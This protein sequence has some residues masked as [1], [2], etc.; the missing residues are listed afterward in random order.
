MSP[1]LEL[2]RFYHFFQLDNL[3]LSYS[4]IKRA[5]HFTMTRRLL[6]LSIWVVFKAH[7]LLL[8][9]HCVIF[10]SS[11]SMLCSTLLV[12]SLFKNSFSG[13]ILKIM[14]QKLAYL[15]TI[16]ILTLRIGSVRIPNLF[17]C[18]WLC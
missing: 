9:W 12:H 14:G 4:N 7:L 2:V 13:Y 17:Q 1:L 16:T 8:D 5:V 15:N 3:T 18:C 11:S 6:Q 10:C